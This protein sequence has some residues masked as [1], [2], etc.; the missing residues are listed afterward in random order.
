MF[1]KIYLISLIISL[2]IISA[3]SEVTNKI[4]SRVDNSIITTLDIYNKT[5]QLKFLNNKVNNLNQGSLYEIALQ[6]LVR[7]KIKENYLVKQFKE[8]TITNF[9]YLNSII[10]NK[11]KNLGFDTSKEF[12][13]EMVLKGI[14]YENFKDELIID[15][16]WN[17]MIFEKYSSK[18]VINIESLKQQIKEKK[19][20]LIRS[21]KIKEI[22]YQVNNKKLINTKYQEIKKDILK[23]G[24]ENSALR[25]STSNTANVGGNLG[26]ISEQSIDPKI[27]EVINRTPIKNFSGPIRIS[28]GFIILYIDDV[29]E[30][31]VS[32]DEEEELNQIINH[33]KKNHLDNFS[34]LYFQK[35]KKDVK[36]YVE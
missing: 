17:Q 13:N 26:W 8:I 28:S 4:V 6:S 9:D 33:K 11:Y 3:K 20:K 31:T 1:S 24:F 16:M 35:I 34:N 19:E 25:Y 14:N 23:N 27:L 15:L 29:K 18:L 10:E 22:V 5:N 36:I 12:Q 2:S 32:L 30:S 21:F 7:Y